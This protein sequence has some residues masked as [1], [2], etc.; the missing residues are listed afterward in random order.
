MASTPLKKYASPLKEL[1]S[2][3]KR[4]GIVKKKIAAAPPVPRNPPAQP[5]WMLL[6]AYLLENAHGE[7][8]S[9]ETLLQG[10]IDAGHELGR[11]PRRTVK[12]SVVSPHL[13]TV[14]DLTIVNGV[15][16]VGLRVSGPALV[17][18]V[19]SKRRLP[20]VQQARPNPRPVS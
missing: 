12:Q 1:A 20:Q 18:Y 7:P 19:P 14:F 4:I 8:L 17:Q 9:F 2:L 13:R 5:L 3:T 6:Q 10:M 11:Y 15:E 16:L